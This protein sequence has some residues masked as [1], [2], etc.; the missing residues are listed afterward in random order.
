MAEDTAANEKFWKDYDI[1]DDVLSTGEAHIIKL[2][3]IKRLLNERKQ[4]ETEERAKLRQKEIKERSKQ[5]EMA[6]KEKQILY[7]LEKFE[8]EMSEKE[9]EK[10]REM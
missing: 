5:L 2:N 6:E 9:K 7:E 4:E 3:C 10:E 8:L 1:F